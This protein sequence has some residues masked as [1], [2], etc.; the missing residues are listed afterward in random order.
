[1]S[2]R[3]PSYLRRRVGLQILGLL[4]VLTAM[5]QLLELLDVTTEILQRGQGLAGLAYYALLRTPAELL[6]ALPLAVLLGAATSLHAMARGLEITALRASG[7]GM[8]RLFA[9]F[10]PLLL[11]LAGAQLVLLQTAVPGAEAELKRWWKANTPP[12]EQAAP[13]W[14]STRSGP[15]SIDAVSPDGR[16]LRGVR[17]YERQGGLMV[18][19]IRAAGADW[20][21]RGWQLSD[22]SEL[23]LEAEGPRRVHDDAREW[24]TNLHP[25][26]VLRLGLVR[27][28]LSSMMLADVITG[29]RV[30]SQPLSY[31][32]TAL[33]RSFAAP[34]GV[35]VMLLLALPTA[36]TQPRHSGGGRAMV[37]ALVL[38]LGFLLFDGIVASLGSSGQLPPLSTA[39]TAPLL[40]AAIGFLRLWACEHL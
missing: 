1:M 15:V 31:Y 37:M 29:S 8:M 21:G 33:Y 38:G 34:F 25:D 18:A 19:R 12:G 4:A 35:F 17:I 32:Q 36:A 23:R 22:V 11:L 28:Q 7:V 14:V 24:Q 2:A 5:M 13:L 16:T 30:G 20:T 40:F 39:L 10:L 3:L 26:E 9:W 6:L 27:P